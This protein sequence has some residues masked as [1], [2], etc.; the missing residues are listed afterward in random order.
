MARYYVGSTTKDS[1]R[2]ALSHDAGCDLTGD[3]CNDLS[4]WIE[5]LEE[6]HARITALE[7]KCAAMTEAGEAMAGDYAGAKQH[8]E[9]HHD[10]TWNHADKR[11]AAW[12][13]AVES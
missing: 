3:D 9:V 2:E 8:C 5:E 12:R 10:C 4:A 1:L 13:K 6:D 7:A 11:L